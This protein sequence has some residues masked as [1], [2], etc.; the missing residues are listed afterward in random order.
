VKYEVNYDTYR[1]LFEAGMTITFKE[2]E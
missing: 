2:Q 1:E